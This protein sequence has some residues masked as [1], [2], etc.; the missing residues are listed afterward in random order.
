LCQS[1][2]RRC[3]TRAAP[4]DQDIKAFFIIHEDCL[5]ATREEY[6]CDV[7][8]NLTYVIPDCPGL[9]RHPN[10]AEAGDWG[11]DEWRFLVLIDARNGSK[12]DDWGS[13]IPGLAARDRAWL[14]VD[15]VGVDCKPI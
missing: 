1:E 4:N 13:E 14:E 3:T 15:R 7:A 12:P 9:Q 6:G 10:F 11:R 5:V 8:G 2:R